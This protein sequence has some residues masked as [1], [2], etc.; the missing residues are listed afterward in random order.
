MPRRPILCQVITRLIVGGAQR[1]VL[2]L[3][4]GMRS[5]FDVRVVCGPDLGP[6]GSLHEE[7]AGVAP[8]TVVESLRRDVNLADDLRVV[9]HLRRVLGAMRPAIVHTHSSKAGIVGRRAAH[10]LPVRTAHTVHGW[11]HT[12]TDSPARRR[13]LVYL[14]RMAAQW[15]DR[16]IAVSPEVQEE[17]LSLGIGSADDY[18]VI[19][20]GVDFT[21]TE[22]DFDAA[23]RRARAALGLSPEA[24]V[25]GWVGRFVPQKDLETLVLAIQ[26]LVSGNPDLQAVLIGDGPLRVE[27]ERRLRELGLGPRVTLTGLRS[28]ARSLMPAFDLLLHLSRWEG[29]P[30]VVQEAIAERVP[31]VATRTAGVPGLVAPQLTGYIVEPGDARSAVSRAEAVLR[32]PGLR[33][34]LDRASVADVATPNR[35]ETMLAHHAKLYDELLTSS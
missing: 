23:R 17:G 7:L 34:P 26:G 10:R 13:T 14:E 12:P 24:E 4:R 8:V 30:R 32:D 15:S 33:A 22:P 31:V 29:Q 6:E 9:G 19:P 28:D 21:P 20:E 2:E 1:T 5:D 35:V 18:V 16:L 11:G 27:L 25:V 3:C